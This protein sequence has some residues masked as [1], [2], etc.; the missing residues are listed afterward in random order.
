MLLYQ[1]NKP[2]MLAL[3]FL[4][5][6][7]FLSGSCQQKE[8]KKQKVQKQEF[9][10]V[11]EMRQFIEDSVHFHVV[12]NTRVPGN[13]RYNAHMYYLVAENYSEDF[14]EQMDFLD[15]ARKFSEYQYKLSGIPVAS[16][17][18]A[19]PDREYI[20]AMRENNGP[21]ERKHI[22]C[23]V[24]FPVSDSNI[25][26]RIEYLQY[27]VQSEKYLSIDLS[28]NSYPVRTKPYQFYQSS[29]FPMP[30]WVE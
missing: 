14:F 9:K 11:W 4:C 1:H 2:K 22:I 25:T 19:K 26:N 17:S 7:L 23:R 13:G 12:Y 3:F 8:E 21:E 15:I 16:V 10:D 28:G 27:Y 18:Y 20:T 5:M 30:A 29:L 6:T 24:D